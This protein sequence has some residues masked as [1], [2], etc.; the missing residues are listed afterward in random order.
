MSIVIQT[1][2]CIYDPGQE[3]FLMQDSYGRREWHDT[4]NIFWINE[5]S[6][7]ASER[8]IL[9]RKR[10]NIPDALNLLR[11]TVIIKDMILAVPIPLRV[12]TEEAEKEWVLN[13]KLEN[14]KPDF[15]LAIEIPLDSEISEEI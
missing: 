3:L 1:Y 12:R 15:T 14:L 7:V 8:L 10:P 13:D 2:W 11:G 6:K 4:G 9:F 5:K